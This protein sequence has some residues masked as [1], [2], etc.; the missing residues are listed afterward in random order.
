M[1]P[2]TWPP[3]HYGAAGTVRMGDISG[4]HMCENMIFLHSFFMYCDYKEKRFK[5]LSMIS[6]KG[7]QNY[8]AFHRPFSS[9]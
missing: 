2:L 8:P 9:F 4:S 7:G 5:A 1:A 6:V 3:A